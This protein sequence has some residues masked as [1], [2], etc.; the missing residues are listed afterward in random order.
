MTIWRSLLSRP[1]AAPDCAEPEI[2]QLAGAIA[3]RLRALDLVVASRAHGRNFYEIF[4]SSSSRMIVLPES[5]EASGVAALLAG[6]YTPPT[7]VFE[8]INSIT[9]GLGRRMVAA[10]LDSLREH[11]GVFTHVR[12]NDLSPV[13]KDGRRW[14][15]HIADENAD[16]E[17]IITHDPDTTHRE[18]HKT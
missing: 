12:V 1:G 10:V 4:A 2:A 3:D 6:A 17:W 18:T 9:P 5:A 15:E 8:R 13:Q 14:W 16:F 11:P 7:L